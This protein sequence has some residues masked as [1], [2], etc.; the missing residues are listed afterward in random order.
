MES[1][2]NLY[3]AVGRGKWSPYDTTILSC[4]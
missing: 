1:V 2:M 3:F 4:Y